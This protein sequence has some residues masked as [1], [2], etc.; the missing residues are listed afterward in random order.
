MNIKTGMHISLFFIISPINAADNLSQQTAPEPS[1]FKDRIGTINPDHVGVNDRQPQE[2]QTITIP[3][4]I[5]Q[6]DTPTVTNV[7]QAENGI[8]F[9]CCCAALQACASLISDCLS[10]LDNDE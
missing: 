5:T 1:Q 3:S 10:V 8:N 9:E 7:R 4:L 2:L 6:I